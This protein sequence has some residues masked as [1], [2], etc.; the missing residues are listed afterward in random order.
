VVRLL[1]KH[2]DDS[3]LSDV[4]DLALV[5]IAAG[6]LC[7][8]LIVWFLW[9]LYTTFWFIT[10]PCTIYL[11]YRYCTRPP[12]PIAAKNRTVTTQEHIKTAMGTK[13]I[14]TLEKF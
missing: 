7:I 5:V 2:S 11:A 12:K 8:A 4:K 9:V 14:H 3:I 1:S 10:I 6:I 13:I